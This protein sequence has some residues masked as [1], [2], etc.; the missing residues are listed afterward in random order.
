VSISGCAAIQDNPRTVRGAGIGAA[1][2]AGTGA[3]IGAIVGGKKGAG[4]GAAIG[5]VVGLLGGGII[6]KY[7]DGQAREMEA[8]ISTQDELRREQE[9]LTVVMASDVLF[10][11]DSATLAPGARPKVR[12]LGDVMQRYPRTIVEVAGHTDSSGSDAHNLDLSRRRA[13]SIADELVAAGVAPGRISVRGL[14][15]SM[16][17]VSNASAAGRQENRRVEIVINPDQGLRSEQGGY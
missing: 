8:V 6:G 10:D 9:Q 5:A 12:Q 16:P 3:A 14:G 7:L 2:G 15:E 17:L 13:E 1:A 4:Q 11:V